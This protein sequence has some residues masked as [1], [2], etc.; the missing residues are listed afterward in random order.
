MGAWR[1]VSLK[2][3]DAPMLSDKWKPRAMDVFKDTGIVVFRR[4]RALALFDA[5]PFGSGSGGHSHSDTLSVVASVGDQELLIDSGTFSYMDPE[6]RTI[7]RGSSAHNTVRID[8]R[9]QGIA[10]GPFRWAQ[11]PEV[12]LLEFSSDATKAYAVGICCFQGFSHRRSVEFADDVL[13]IVDQIEGRGG[14]HDIEQFWHFA[15][16]PREISPGTWAIGEVA[17]F[18]AEGGIVEP[19]W[20]SRC[21]GSKEPAWTAAVRRRSTLPLTLH[22]RIR[23]RL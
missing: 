8:G 22:A 21:F 17:E 23:M 16:E 19:S 9:D 1:K 3:P 7:F 14:E 11:K 10:G 4:G 18:T 2:L 15:T 13:S 20:R 12:K 6:W 5:G